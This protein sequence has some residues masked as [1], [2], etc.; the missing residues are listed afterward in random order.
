M[1]GTTDPRIDAYIAKSA[2]FAKPILTHLRGL[3]HKAVPK[4]EETIKWGMPFFVHA[5]EPL[6]SFAAFKQHAVFGFWKAKLM[7]DPQLMA[8]AASEGAMGQLGRLTS[9]RDLPSNKVI[10]GYLK[11]AAA[12]NE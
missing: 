12:L 9:L 8:N 4:V 6:C 2:D 11:E 10:L 3:I 5:G 1:P 7:K